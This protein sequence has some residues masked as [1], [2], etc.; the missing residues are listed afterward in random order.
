MIPVSDNY[1]VQR[2]PIVNWILIG[3]CVLVFFW[4]LSLPREGF[5]ASVI[6]FGL[7]PK[8]LMD[9]PLGHPQ[10][11]ISPV[12]SLFTSMFLY[13][14]FLH[15]LDNMLY[16]HVFGNNVEDSMGHGRFIVFYLLCGVAAALA[17]AFIAPD[18]HDPHG[19]G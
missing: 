2:I 3:T 10:L 18:F 1:P 15:L 11:L 13:S 16:L 6:L 5:Q 12:L 19:G 4:Q 9:A 8:A 14:G 17:Q 7:I